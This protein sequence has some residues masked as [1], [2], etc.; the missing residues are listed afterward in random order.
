M[1]RRKSQEWQASIEQ[2]ETGEL[3]VVE[4]CMLHGVNHKTF[5]A[6]RRALPKH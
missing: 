3:S 2:Q 5:Y 6:R 4:F 1:A